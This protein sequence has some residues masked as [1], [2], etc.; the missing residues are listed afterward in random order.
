[1]TVETDVVTV[2]S[3]DAPR[4]DRRFWVRLTEGAK[5]RWRQILVVALAA[6]PAL[7]MVV[8]IRSGT[9]VQVTDYW[10]FLSELIEPDGSVRWRALSEFQGQH[11]LSVPFVIYLVNIW[12]FG[13]SNIT[14][15]LVVVAIVSVQLLVLWRWIRR[16][17]L[18]PFVVRGALL[19]F[20][21]ALLYSP[22]GAWNFMRA[23]SGT[24]WLTANLLV[25]LAIH[26]A[27]RERTVPA[28]VL[29]VLATIT[30][31][32]GVLVW[33]AV[34]LIVWLRSRPL[35]EKVAVSAL[36]GLAVA[37]YV[38]LRTEQVPTDT[39]RSIDVQELFLGTAR[40]LGRLAG[41]HSNIVVVVGVGLL[42]AV[43]VLVPL[44][45]LRC[46]DQALPFAGLA[47]F[48]VLGAAQIT[49]GRAG[50]LGGDGNLMASR[51]T[52]LGAVTWIAAA[53]LLISVLSTF[54]VG[55]WRR[56]VAIGVCVPLGLVAASAP[57]RGHVE[58]DHSR[59]QARR[60]LH[61]SDAQRLKVSRDRRWFLMI[62][63]PD[64]D[65]RL[66]RLGH[67]P[68]DGRWDADC[69]WLGREFDRPFE[70]SDRAASRFVVTGL[71]D[72]V[73]VNAEVPFAHSA[74]DCVLVLD[75]TGTVVGVGRVAFDSDE[76][77]GTDLVAYAPRS[78]RLVTLVFQLPGE[79][80]WIGMD[81]LGDHSP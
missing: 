17:N 39:I 15:G 76:A 70:D 36:A 2:R 49:Y 21:S 47:V 79:D 80:R 50:G 29:A 46:R 59:E 51:Y 9:H 26:F 42:V 45:V 20:G 11:L 58:I 37:A 55:R 30:Y 10:V 53:A 54:E 34:V 52:S 78:S 16:M 48:G 75:D 4:Y 62:E 73:R 27:S 56:W 77:G 3:P 8:V 33:P 35:V 1:M 81:V 38:A 41:F 44:A 66:E 60:A 24:A 72:G 19:V 71:P 32:T 63:Q 18:V 6:V 43:A 23:M 25:I 40:I 22:H 7:H 61:L 74:L 64:I 12:L 57:F 28:V 68:F 67:H 65:D 69:G 31:G 5:Q 14:L 13:G